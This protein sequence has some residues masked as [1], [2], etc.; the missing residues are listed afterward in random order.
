M[1]QGKEEHHF[2]DIRSAHYDKLFWVKDKHYL[3]AIVKHAD[4]KKSHL[5]LDVGTGTGV[6]A[7][8]IKKHVKHVVVIDTSDSMLSKGVWR[9]MSTIKWDIGESLFLGGLFDRV[10]A[11]MVFHHILDNLDRAVLRCYDVLKPNGKIVVAEGVP[12]T[13]DPDVIEWYTNMFKLKEK[14]RTFTPDIL[15]YIL[16]KNGF[17]GVK[18]NIYIMNKFSINNWLE[19]SGLSGIRQKKI[20]QMHVNADD[21]IKKAYNMRIVNGECFVRTVNMIVTGKK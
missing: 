2:W 7:N 19:N 15:P 16:E 10:F 1:K 12:P 13:N 17:C 3:E 4:L 11:R 6:V 8:A 18:S 14:R 5:V 9:N 20:Y 21:K